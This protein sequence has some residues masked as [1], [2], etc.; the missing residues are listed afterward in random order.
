MDV[1][2]TQRPHCI[3]ISHVLPLKNGKTCFCQHYSHIAYHQSMRALHCPRHTSP[4]LSH[5]YTHPACPQQGMS[6]K[7]EHLALPDLSWSIINHQ[8]ESAQ[9][10]KQT[11]SP[12]KCS[13]AGTKVLLIQQ[14]QKHKVYQ[15]SEWMKANPGLKFGRVTYGGICLLL[16]GVPCNPPCV[17]LK[18]SV[19]KQLS[20]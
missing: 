3:H 14:N 19:A 5:A 20:A 17:L 4:T 15:H 2:R 10:V 16:L 8:T 1:R 13:E 11:A 18:I 12:S 6:T 7:R 9:E